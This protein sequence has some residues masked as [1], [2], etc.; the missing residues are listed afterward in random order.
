M[1]RE[2]VADQAAQQDSASSA[3]A[4]AEESYGLPAPVYAQ[5]L[6]LGPGNVAGLRALLA[7][8]P[9][10]N[11]GILSVASH[12]MG[13]AA[14]RQA[15]GPG[16]LTQDQLR[17]G[18]EFAL[19][20]D[21]PPR[22]P[23]TQEQLR[24]GGEFALEGGT[25]PRNPLTQEQLRPGGEFALEGGTAPRNPLTQE[26][27]RPGGEFALEGGTAPRNPLTQEQI[28]PGGEFALEGDA[29][30]AP[31]AEPAWVAGARKYNEA[32]AE[33]ASNFNSLTGNTCIGADGQLDPQLVSAWQRSHGLDADGKVGPHT[34]AAARQ[35]G[36]VASSQA[37]ARIPV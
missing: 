32:H 17:P 26:Q 36:P 34:V 2:Q 5:V 15:M 11:Q 19:E 16:P 21:T 35:A 18:G 29:P 25:A 27:L 10:F 7:Q 8:Y 28:R 9:N 12:H 14:V 33:L 4:G 1:S 31:A 30:A 3:V 22:K 20:G 24:P 13:A 6:K 37:D 23:L